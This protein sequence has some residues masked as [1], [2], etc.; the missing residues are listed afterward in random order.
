MS[1]ARYPFAQ[2]EPAW[3]ARWEDARAFWCERT[4]RPTWFVMELPPFANGELHLGHARNYAIADACARFRRMTGHDV[5][6]TTGFDTFGLPN[7]IA[8]L[9]AGTHPL[10]LAER[11]SA[12]MSEQFVRLGLSHD[13]RR[14][15]GY[16]VEEYYRWVQWVFLKL[17][18]AGHCVR[19]SARIPWCARCDTALAESLIDNGACWRCGCVPEL[20]DTE[21]W[22][23]RERDF[24]D[25]MLDGLAELD[26]WPQTVKRIHADWIGRRTGIDV[27]LH[28]A[29]DEA[30]VLHVFTGEPQHLAGAAFVA[31]GPDHPFVARLRETRAL[32]TSGAPS[33]LGL[34]A[35]LPFQRRSV[36]LVLATGDRATPPDGAR[37]GIP[38]CDA[39]A[40]TIA[41]ALGI[42]YDLEKKDDPAIAAALHSSGASSP[43]VAYRLRDWNIARQRYWGPPVPVVH[44]ETCGLV[45]VP[46]DELPVVL[47]LDVELTRT[48]SALERDASF[49]AV[50]CP[51]CGRAARRD[52]DTLE[53]YSSP[54]W[55]HWLCMDV[56]ADDPFSRE[57]ARTW[58]PVDVLVGGADQTR[59]CFFHVRMIAKALRRLGIADVDEPVETLIAI[60]MV[61]RDGRKMS[62]SDGQD[63]G[64][65]AL[66]ERFGADTVRLGLLAA[67][68]PANDLNWSEHVL[69][70]AHET[71]VALW[72][73]V[74]ERAERVRAA[75]DVAEPPEGSARRRRL[76][77]AV[78]TAARKITNNFVKHAYHL[79]AL[80]AAQLLERL[81]GFARETER[82]SVYAPADEAVLAHGVRTLLFAFAPLA[83]HIAE[84]LWARCGGDGLLALAPWPVALESAQ[85]PRPRAETVSANA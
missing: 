23:V 57:S 9:E 79:A 48:G 8:A 32:P 68:A 4:G 67:A 26:G 59:S 80:N 63:L 41:D 45:P 24:A 14:I 10:E 77:A 16:H 35:E 61:K 39:G 49:M 1:A 70:R 47:P 36:P 17:Y 75:R 73:L 53:A 64:L 74:A 72:E 65:V 85:P 2:I 27:R 38:A 7:E 44:C 69:W 28:V 62:K 82:G 22:F 51:L 71:L 12:S 34:T 11:Y 56:G 76:A 37:F 20:R 25:E 31:L 3:Q 43:A 42:A 83:P 54:W 19:R 18:A 29:G 84:E 81:T 21:Q 46:D 30:G 6:Y 66:L 33:L 5:L 60:G 13:R 50:D 40:R 15:I 52:T 55:Y 58:L 78:D